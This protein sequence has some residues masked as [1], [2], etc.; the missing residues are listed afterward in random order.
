MCVCV[1]VLERAYKVTLGHTGG[2]PPR[3]ATTN[4]SPRLV[5]QPKASYRSSFSANHSTVNG[6]LKQVPPSVHISGGGVV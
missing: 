4:R 3:D 1:S 2:H 5:I 6:H